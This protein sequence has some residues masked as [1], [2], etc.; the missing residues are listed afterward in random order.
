MEFH[1]RTGQPPAR[2]VWGLKLKTVRYKLSVPRDFKVEIPG[3]GHWQSQG[4]KPEDASFG[5]TKTKIVVP[6]EANGGPDE[7]SPQTRGAPSEICSI[8]S[9]CPSDRILSCGSA[10]P[11]FS[12]VV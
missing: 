3:I 12:A 2:S 11:V 10:S 4:I 9:E 6:P 7:S 8:S 1:V 5:T